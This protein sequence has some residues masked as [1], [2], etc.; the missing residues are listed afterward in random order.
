MTFPITDKVNLKCLFYLKDNRKVD[1]SGLYEGVQDVLS[2]NEK[3]ANVPPNL[4]QILFDDSHRYVGSHD[5]SRV[6]LDMLNPRI[7]K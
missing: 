5:G 2:G 6:L 1:L 3:W 4:F 7:E